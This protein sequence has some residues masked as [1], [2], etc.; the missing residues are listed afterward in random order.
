MLTS[1]ASPVIFAHRGASSHAPENTLSSFQLAIDQG[2]KAIELDVQLTKDQEV[3]VF[4]DTHLNR[5]T[6]G[7]GS[8]K[9]LTLSELK[10]FNAGI[11][12]SPA[13]Q[14]ERI[15][16]LSEVFMSISQDILINIELKN[17]NTPFDELPVKVAS[18][19]RKL[20]AQNRVLVSSY[21]AIALYR[22]HRE[23]PSIPRGLLLQ[24]SLMANF[25]SN[26]PHFL[27]RIQSIHLSYNFLNPELVASFQRSGK[28]VFC[29]TLNHAQDM[30]SALKMG[31]DGF[32]T[33]DPGFAKRI[34][35]QTV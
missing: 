4:H 8:V 10:K 15:P 16:T 14:H 21:N 2:S 3:V 25:H 26:F 9:D 28:K 34:L 7:S 19:I 32:F 11:S 20:N 23:I 6:D 12:F 5:T 30:L 29:F 31:I 17:L 22:F 13:Y 27:K 33:D 1:L 35:A 24:T 18:V